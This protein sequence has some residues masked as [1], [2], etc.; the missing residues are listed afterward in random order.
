MDREPDNL[1]KHS[2]LVL[3]LT[4]TANIANL[5]FHVVMGRTL[6]KEE[7]AI[8]VS[9]LGIALI[10][11]TPMVAMQNTLAHFTGRLQQQNRSGDIRRLVRSWI[12]KILLIGTPAVLLILICCNRAA[13]ALHMPSSVPLIITACAIFAALFVP[14]L[15][16]ALQGIQ[17]FVWMCVTANAWGI[18][19]LILGAVMVACVSASAISGVTAHAVG[20]V[21]SLLVGTAGI[22]LVI[23]KGTSSGQ[24]LDQSDRYFFLSLAAMLGFSVLMY[25]DMILVK[26]FFTNPEDYGNY[27]RAATIARTLVFLPFPIAGVLFPKVVSE[28]GRSAADAGTLIKA[29]LFTCVIIAGSLTLFLLFPKIV[30]LALYKESSPTAEMVR[31]VRLLS[32]A[33]APLGLTFMMMNFELAQRRFACLWILAACAAALVGGICVFH[34]SLWN[35][36]IT[37]AG[38]ASVSA[39]VLAALSFRR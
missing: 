22:A 18:V 11:A 6:P 3:A 38:A 2:I 39:I 8:L 35:V 33:M 24:E 30:L 19:R 31:L 17:S 9:V 26:H 36:V 23:P 13:A 4:H 32:C 14:V 5:L 7:Y 20:M 34:A 10:F 29:L 25:A 1:I 12:V 15:S 21:I 28:G 16:G 27:A 37:L